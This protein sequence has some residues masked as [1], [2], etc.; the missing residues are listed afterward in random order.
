MSDVKKTLLNY[1]TEIVEGRTKAIFSVFENYQAISFPLN[2]VY[3]W[4][5]P[6]MNMI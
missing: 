3:I 1:L 5:G 4:H 2:I 6:H